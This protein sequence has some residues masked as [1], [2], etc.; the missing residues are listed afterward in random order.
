MPV[1]PDISKVLKLNLSFTLK[2]ALSRSVI[3][4]NRPGFSVD[5][6]VLDFVGKG[7]SIGRSFQL[8]T[9]ARSLVLYRSYPQACS[10][11][12]SPPS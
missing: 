9:P 7:F 12:F 3:D 4:E 8:K 6:F 11:G 1:Y 5:R 10:D 2:L